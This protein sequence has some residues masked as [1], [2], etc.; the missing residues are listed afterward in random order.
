MKEYL[1]LLALLA[2]PLLVLILYGI[3]GYTLSINNHRLAKLNLPFI[4]PPLA[5]TIDT[6]SVF[7]VLSPQDSGVLSNPN[8]SATDDIVRA[9]AV[10][11]VASTTSVNHC[12]RILFF[13][14]SMVEGLAPRFADYAARNGYELYSVCWYAS[15]TVGWAENSDTLR[16]F[17]KWSAPDYVVISLGGNE[18]RTRDFRHRTECIEKIMHVIGNRPVVWIAPPSW[19]KEPTITSIILSAVGRK[20]YFDST[21]L[22]YT[23]GKDHIHPTEG[24]SSRWMDSIAVW[25]QG[26]ETLNPIPMH[27]PE[28]GE[29][30]KAG[31]RVW[32]R[33]YI[34][35]NAV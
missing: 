35:P 7:A 9:D 18:L 12:H 30:L 13:G 2:L 10:Y 29:R 27:M 16:H 22:R 6:A 28:R 24:S 25:M 8:I 19:I 17:L 34:N 3:S 4:A 32:N 5:N 33:R 26:K 21:R 20:R 31:R 11:T 14:D 15:T 23:R 1:R